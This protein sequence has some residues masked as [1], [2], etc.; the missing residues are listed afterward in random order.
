MQRVIVLAV[1]LWT[2]VCQAAISTSPGIGGGGSDVAMADLVSATNILSDRLIATNTSIRSDFNSAQN[3]QELMF[4]ALVNTTSNS[5]KNF[6]VTNDATR[7]ST[8]EGTA[9]NLT[10]RNKATGDALTVRSNEGDIV[11]RTGTDGTRISTTAYSSEDVADYDVL[12][13]DGDSGVTAHGKVATNHIT[14]NFLS[15]LLAGGVNAVTNGESREL[16]FLGPLSLGPAGGSAIKLTT[17]PDEDLAFEGEGVNFRVFWG[18]GN[19]VWASKFEGDGGEITNLDADKITQGTLPSARI[20]DGSISTNKIDATFRDWVESKG[21]GGGGEVTLAELQSAT[22]IISD[23]LIATNSLMITRLGATNDALVARLGATN[24]AWLSYLSATNTAID[25]RLNAASN[26]LLSLIESG[27]G[28]SYW[29]TN[30]ASGGLLLTNSQGF[31]VYDDGGTTHVQITGENGMQFLNAANYQQNE[32]SY[33][34]IR[35]W[36]IS[37]G[38]FWSF[39]EDMALDINSRI[40]EGNW[41]VR[42]DLEVVGE[43]TYSTAAVTN[44]SVNQMLM[45]TNQFAGVVADFALGSSTYTNLT[46]NLT[47]TGIANFDPTVENGMIITVRA[48]GANRTVTPAASWDRTQDS[49]TITNGTL[50]K[51]L[52]TA[53]IGVTTNI[54][55]VFYKTP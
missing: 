50:A 49:Y 30:T 40:L 15:L 2:C 48:S 29:T 38:Q 9:Y 4:V 51:F 33:D 14:A 5:L 47:F 32:V 22:N 23:R 6:A 20:G 42:G 52:I 26:H 1:L 16:R 13:R 17:T 19:G 34:S 53:Q 37:S 21:G 28:D 27:G 44:L 7:V 41:M 18:D 54:S 11:F 10:V 31:R 8:N 3:L 12:F 46:G 24:S 55:C 36:S 45:T 25:V 43:T 39:D 35:V